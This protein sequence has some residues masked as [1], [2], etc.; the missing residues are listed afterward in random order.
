MSNTDLDRLTGHL[1]Q[2]GPVAVAV[3]GGVDSITLA[4]LAHRLFPGRCEIFHAVSPA[5]PP[6][7]T[8]RVRSYASLEHWSL[9]VIDAQEFEDENYL[10]N[11]ARR[12]YFCK[13]NLYGTIAAHTGMTIASGT[14]LD[15]L[16]DFR[17]GLSAAEEHDVVHPY[18][19]AQIRKT[20][21]RGIA[22]SLGLTDVAELP[23]GPCL[24]SRVET[25]LLIEADS[26]GKVNNIENKLTELLQPSVVRC[27]VRHE[28]IVVELDDTTLGAL[29]ASQRAQIRAHVV[30]A[31][32]DRPMRIARYHQGSAFLRQ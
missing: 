7:A 22:A 14:N 8:H 29:T 5:V 24:A 17:P 18:V 16:Q 6:E 3:S 15:D 19:A 2:L 13:T 11:P 21:V 26:L 31:W 9:R 10:S 27:R 32:P 12:C 20:A 28:G 23:A 1:N 4:V 25:G 30:A